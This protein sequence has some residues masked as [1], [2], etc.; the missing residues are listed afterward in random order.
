MMLRGTPVTARASDPDVDAPRLTRAQL[1]ALES[2]ATAIVVTDV[3]GRIEWVNPSF[4]RMTGYAAEEVVGQPHAMLREGV[5]DP[6][7]YGAMW[8]A[9]LGGREW[10]GELVGRRKDGST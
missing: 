5:I 9:V 2:T 3:A 1:A 8:Q 6:G 4:T 7:P 10:H